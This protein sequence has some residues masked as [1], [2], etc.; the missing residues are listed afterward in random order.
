[1]KIYEYVAQKSTKR[2]T[3][4]VII[5]ASAGL[6]FF[7]LPSLM[8]DIPYAW[9]SQMLG[10]VAVT[11][12]IFV[13]AKGLAR[14]FVYAIV[15]DGERRLDLTVSEIERNGKKQTTVCR[16][17]LGN[18]TEAYLLY[19]ERSSD[20]RKLKELEAR[21]RREQ[22]KRYSYCYESAPTPTCLLFL[23]ECGEPLFI[24]LAPDEQLF[25]YVE[26]FSQKK[27]NE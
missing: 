7:L 11:A 10:V 27:E 2:S 24:K 12:M 22:R 21:A 25:E 6:G 18:I 23:E 13:I 17:A 19:P 26:R 9:V 15:E 4:L 3:G 14:T 5:F 8:K 1:M 20:A 16:V